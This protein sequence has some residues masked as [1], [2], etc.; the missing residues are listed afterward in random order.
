MHTINTAELNAV[1]AAL[2]SKKTIA[3]FL[4]DQQMLDEVTAAKSLIIVEVCQRD[5]VI[6][7]RFNALLQQH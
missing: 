3:E 7:A 1:L 2:D 5:P 6:R 4:E